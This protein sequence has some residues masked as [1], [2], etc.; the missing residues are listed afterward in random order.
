M[1]SNTFPEIVLRQNTIPIEFSGN[2][3]MNL[4]KNT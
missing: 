4:Y 3:G 1:I 2:I